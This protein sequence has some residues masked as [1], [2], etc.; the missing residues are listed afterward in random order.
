MH[1]HQIMLTTGK[2]LRT[3]P[4]YDEVHAH[5]LVQEAQS[6]GTYNKLNTLNKQLHRK[7]YMD[8]WDTQ[9]SLTSR[10]TVFIRHLAWIILM[11]G[12]LYLFSGL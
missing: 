5:R 1:E 4:F 2:N 7:W 6:K 12:F 3:E 9:E 11:I 8:E 10:K